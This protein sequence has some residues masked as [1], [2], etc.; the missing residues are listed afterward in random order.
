MVGSDGPCTAWE[1]LDFAGKLFD[2]HDGQ[3]HLAGVL[4]HWLVENLRPRQSELYH[5]L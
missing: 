3:A 4:G 2:R 5:Y 1:L